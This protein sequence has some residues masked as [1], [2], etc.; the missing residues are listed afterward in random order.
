S[1]K[2]RKNIEK[3]SFFENFDRRC[4]KSKIQTDRIEGFRSGTTYK[5]IFASF[6]FR[7]NNQILSLDDFHN[8]FL[9]NGITI[10]EKPKEVPTGKNMRIK[11]PDGTIVEYAEHNKNS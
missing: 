3:N 6:R 10:L 8:Y 2:I 7:R 11:H 4:K 5:N 1:Y 9:E